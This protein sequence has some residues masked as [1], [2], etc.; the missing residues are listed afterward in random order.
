LHHDTAPTE[1][2]DA[3]TSL[4]RTFGGAYG[5]GVAYAKTMLGPHA[6]EAGKAA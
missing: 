5:I 2:Y 1:T 4:A 6:S 3:T